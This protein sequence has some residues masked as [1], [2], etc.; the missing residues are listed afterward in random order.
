MDWRERL[1]KKPCPE[2]LV[3]RNP[4]VD[5]VQVKPPRRQVWPYLNTGER[6]STAV[7]PTHSR[8]AAPVAFMPKALPQ[9]R[10]QRFGRGGGG[11]GD[12]LKSQRRKPATRAQPVL[13]LGERG[14]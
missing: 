7:S 6:G 3:Q 13:R 8:W 9:S 10:S 1:R 4:A 5:E 11:L 2:R 12:W 14:K